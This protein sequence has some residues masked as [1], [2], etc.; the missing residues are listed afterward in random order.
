MKKYL[1]LFITLF[2]AFAASAQLVIT[3]I[4]YNPPESGVDSL[5]YIELYNETTADIDLTNYIIRD[6]NPHTIAAGTVPANGYAI[7]AINPGAIMSVL[8][9]ASVEIADIALSN[10]G[11]L[12]TLEDPTGAVLDEVNYDDVAPWPTSD[13][14][15]GGEGATIELCDV[16]SDNSDASNWSV[17]TND[18]G[19]T[20]DGKAFLGTPAAENTASCEFVPDYTVEVSSNMF[21]PADITIQVNESVR[22]MNLGGFHNVNGSIETFPNNPEGFLNGGASGDAWIFDKTFTIPGVYDYQ[23]D[24]HSGLGMVGTVT[25]VGD[26]EPM[27]PL[28]D[29]GVINTINSEGVGDSIG[30]L[31]RLEGIV[32]GANLNPSGLQFAIIDDSGDAIGVFNNGNLGYTYAEGDMIRVTGRIDQFFGLLQI[33]E[34]TAVEL[35]SSGNN[36]IGPELVEELSEA[37]ESKFVQI[38]G[39]VMENQ[40]DWKGD[41]TSFNVD[42]TTPGGG[43]VTLRIDEESEVANWSEGPTVG[44]WRIMGIGGQFDS[45]S[46]FDSGYQMFPRYI[47]DFEAVAAVEDELEATIN[48]YPNPATHVV[49]IA[50]D[51]LL[52]D[53]VLY[54]KFGEVISKG[55]FRS[56][57]D[58]TELP[59]GHYL[60]VLSKGDKS[61]AVQFVK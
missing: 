29:I 7:L 47:S 11:E 25:V 49:N 22:W 48:V 10:G 57:L 31:C 35:I 37:T 34:V 1:L 14:G 40:D 52:D 58:V 19:A 32:H 24:P 50:S 2:F 43:T 60:I 38:A 13:D 28:Y 44:T 39:L 3:E 54:N 33:E 17:A 36:L 46:P 26:I 4:S 5:E 42:F 20:L 8:D 6:N 9:V 23:C 55:K 45:D 27:I 51:V 56:S 18:T 12:I 16:T 30:T 53:Y 59:S 21:T 15:T 61:K 41:G